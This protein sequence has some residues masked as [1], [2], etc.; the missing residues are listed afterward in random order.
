[1]RRLREELG[2]RITKGSR[3]QQIREQI[4]SF[5]ISNSSDWKQWA[6]A[7]KYLG[8]KYTSPTADFKRPWSP[9]KAGR[10]VQLPGKY[11]E[12]GVRVMK[13]REAYPEDRSA[14]SD[15]ATSGLENFNSTDPKRS[16]HHH[17]LNRSIHTGP[18][19]LSPIEEFSKLHHSGK[20]SSRR[21]AI[22]NNM[23]FSC[24]GKLIPYPNPTKTATNE[25]ST[26][27][28]EIGLGR[29][30]TDRDLFTQNYSKVMPRLMETKVEMS[31]DSPGV[32]HKSPSL[33][34]MTQTKTATPSQTQPVV[35]MKTDSPDLKHVSPPRI[36][37]GV[38][39]DT[40][41][42]TP[43]NIPKGALNSSDNVNYTDLKEKPNAIENSL[44]TKEKSLNDSLEQ[45][46]KQI[47]LLQ[48]QLNSVLSEN[49][50]LRT[51]LNPLSERNKKALSIIKGRENVRPLKLGNADVGLVLK[52]DGLKTPVRDIRDHILDLL[53]TD[54]ESLFVLAKGDECCTETCFP[55][56][57][58]NT[59][60]PFKS[61][62]RKIDLELGKPGV[63]VA[64]LLRVTPEGVNV[65]NLLNKTPTNAIWCNAGNSPLLIK[66]SSSEQWSTML[67]N[68]GYA[69][70]LGLHKANNKVH[71][72]SVSIRLDNLFK[73]NVDQKQSFA[74]CFTT[75]TSV[76]SS[77]LNALNSIHRT[78]WSSD[79]KTDCRMSLDPP[80][81]PNISERLQALG[82]QLRKRAVIRL[83]P[84]KSADLP[85]DYLESNIA[86]IKEWVANLQR[87]NPKLTLPDLDE[88]VS[89]WETPRNGDR[90]KILRVFF[91][92]EVGLE[93]MRD[94]LHGSKLGLVYGLPH[95]LFLMR[96]K[97]HV[98]QIRPRGRH[99][100]S[101]F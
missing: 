47:Q 97:I 77:W 100:G 67:L 11:P 41:I 23:Q 17:N 93:I 35:W 48:S 13:V 79:I 61:A 92:S 1:M 51:A 26:Q 63:N 15:Q 68:P 10:D 40:K 29:E 46:K 59:G 49:D 62:I 24:T 39:D 31:I 21:N 80:I 74:I 3:K 60:Q 43:V 32:L 6:K 99:Q 95:K 88:V 56:K 78:K 50:Q 42:P 37:M 85:P 36:A 90:F 22:A 2:L 27:S 69:I 89:A 53:P 44:A 34:S 8:D 52:L 98:S 83:A 58:L 19:I 55:S 5:C 84:L 87:L 20:I 16:E 64:G 73:L 75:G 18:L 71:I 38:G 45:A 66:I 94:L 65:S 96:G 4:I 82:V 25:R 72:S 12:K 9:P 81:H 76:I 30:S 57:P 54:D 28:T 91:K 70:V 101:R 33:K 86:L 14:L 7:R